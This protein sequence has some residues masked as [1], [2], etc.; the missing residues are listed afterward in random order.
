MKLCKC[1]ERI[2]SIVKCPNCFG[3]TKVY[4][5]KVDVVPVRNSVWFNS[6]RHAVCVF[7]NFSVT[8]SFS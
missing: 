5:M 7:L 4:F 8:L 3:I 6:R 2:I 1:R